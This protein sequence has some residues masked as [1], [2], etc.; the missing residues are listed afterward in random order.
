MDDVSKL[1][2]A[3]EDLNARLRDEVRLRQELER[4]CHLLE[5]LAHRDPASGLRTETYLR[6]RVQEE[7][8]RSIRYPSATSLVT[9]AAP[10][11]ISDTLAGLG[12]RLGEELRT[13]DHVFSL[14]SGGLAILLVETPEEGARRVLDRLAADLEQFV[15]GYGFSVTTFPVDTNLADEFL[16]LAMDRH[17]QV[18]QRISPNGHPNS[19]SASAQLH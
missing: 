9:V 13:T 8:E 14:S 12:R 5:K 19:A 10:D 3:V 15:S 18:L 6:A 2:A 7:I 11:E 1:T 16:K 17:D 4:R